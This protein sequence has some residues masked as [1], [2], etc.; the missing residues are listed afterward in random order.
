MR[1]SSSDIMK[2]KNLLLGVS[3]SIAAYKACD[4]VRRLQDNH[5][6]VSV[7]MTACAEKFVTPL[8]FE[9]LTQRP[10][11]RDM[12]ARD[13]QW[14]MA[15]ISLAQ[16]AQVMVI[17]PA[18]AN[19][20]GKLAAGLADDPVTCVAITINAPLLI[21]PAMNTGMYSNA[22]VQRNISELKKIGMNFINPK[23]GRLACGDT[24]AGAL[25]E[26][27]EILAAIKSLE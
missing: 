27:N 21:A 18:T 11:C 3:G 4:L 2:K 17:A 5:Y 20:I 10:V 24:G 12:F 15:H 26:I 16:W 19:I 9:V 25:A 7:V 14:D 13:G 22:I 8:T 6:E 23:E 1:L